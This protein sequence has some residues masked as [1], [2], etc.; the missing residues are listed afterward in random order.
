MPKV[1]SEMKKNFRFAFRKEYFGGLL[2]DFENCTTEILNS[3]EYDFLEKI[4]NGRNFFIQNLQN[5]KLDKFI[6]RLQQKNI[7]KITPRGKILINNIRRILPPQISP[8]DYLSAPLKVYDTYTRKCNL[9]C[10]HC[11]ASANYNFIEKRR[12][13]LQTKIIMRK[14]YKVG[15]ME[16][17]FTGGEPTTA[18]DLFDAIKIA[19]GFGMKVVL[20]TNGCW[21]SDIARKIFLSGVDELII[22]IEGKEETHDKRR[23]KGS[24]KKAIKTLD[25]ICEYNQKKHWKKLKV[26]LNT[27]IGRD[28]IKDIQYTSFL[29]AKYGCDVKF[30][31]LKI[32]GRAYKNLILFPREYMQFAK[33]VQQLRQNSKIKKSG[34]KIILNHKDL[35]NLSYQDRSI[36]PHPFNYSQ[37]SA[38]T[39]AMDVLPDGRT[40]A[41]SF[42][43]DNPDF[44]GPNILDVSVYEAWQH[45]IMERFRR[46]NKE[47]CINCKF[48]MKQCR[49]PC[50][51]S[52]LL[53]GGKIKGTKLKGRD[54]Y[55]FKNLLPC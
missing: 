31:P 46:A 51:A 17:N 43:M 21:H 8:K 12:T 28:N 27:A 5:S 29:G 37:C 50:R 39:T 26:I 1:N 16:W 45:P 4:K 18:P 30:V 15:V 19:K 6:T 23:G 2:L 35:F 44:I 48:Y 55:C 11:Y 25:K 38:L 3:E 7:I 14:F 32:G 40:V 36:F 20:N 9:F 47:D 34:I 33:K 22:S 13:I 53:S 54:P 10:K 42:L 41:C 49:G 24:F 52:I